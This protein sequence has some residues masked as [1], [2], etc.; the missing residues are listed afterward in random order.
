M[1]R[2]ARRTEAY[3]WHSGAH[4]RFTLPTSVEPPLPHAIALARATTELSHDLLVHAIVVI[5]ATGASTRAVSSARPSAPVVAIT[6]HESIYRRMN[7]LWGVI[8]ILV[9]KI[10]REELHEL[11]RQE[12]LSHHMASADDNILL[13]RGFHPDPKQSVPSITILS[14]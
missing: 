9:G 3:Q 5:S 14:V 10:K 7:L 1:N 12:V 2:I 11:A 6:E 4:G 13:V 8:P